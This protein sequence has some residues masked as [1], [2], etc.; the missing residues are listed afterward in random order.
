[1]VKDDF[2]SITPK[3]TTNL[4]GDNIEEKQIPSDIYINSPKLKIDKT[5]ESN[6]KGEEERLKYNIG[7]TNERENSI[8]KKVTLLEKTTNGRLDKDSI[9]VKDGNGIDIPKDNY[10]IV[11]ENGKITLKFKDDIYILGKNSNKNDILNKNNIPL[12]SN[13][14]YDKINIT[15]D[16]V[17]EKGKD[18]VSTSIVNSN[19]N[20][21]DE[22]GNDNSGIA[23]K[24]VTKV[25]SV[26]GRAVE[27]E[28]FKK[29]TKLD[30][31]KESLKQNVK[32]GDTNT[33]T[34]NILNV[35]DN[36]ARIV[37]VE[38][39][40]QGN[41]KIKKDS[42][43]I[44]NSKGEDITNNTNV[45]LK[46][47]ITDKKI[48]AIIDNIPKDEKYKIVYDVIYDESETENNV[49]TISKVRGLNTEE[50]QIEDTTNVN[51]TIKDTSLEI[52]K[53]SDKKEVKAGDINTYTVTVK[54]T[55]SYDSRDTV[56]EDVLY[57]DAKYIKDTIKVVDKDNNII[58]KSKYTIEWIDKK[59]EKDENRFKIK[60]PIIEKGK[61]IIVTY[62]VQYADLEET[63]E[64]KNI[65]RAKGTNTNLAEP[66]EKDGV[67]VISKGV[68]KET[69]VDITKK[70]EK[71]E[72]PAGKKN[73][74]TI[75]IRN[76]GDYSARNVH[77]E[78]I[79][80][81]NAK[82]LKDTISYDKNYNLKVEWDGKSPKV[83][84]PVLKSKEEYIL[85][86]YM[87]YID[88]EQDYDVTNTVKIKGDNIKEK[89]AKEKV[90]VK[91]VIKETTLDIIKEVE[92]KTVKDGD[93]NTYTTSIT[94]TGDYTARNVH[95]E[96]N[97]EGNANIIKTSVKVINS[98]GEDI[99]KTLKKEDLV[100]K[101][102]NIIVNIPNISSKEK[103]KIIYD[104][105]YDKSEKDNIVKNY[106]K[107]KRK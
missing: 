53:K 43:R 1:M 28:E 82:Y 92:K 11:E 31:S 15:Y 70:A 6:Y 17:K 2:E 9:K 84:I 91:G 8:A 44:L 52:S 51:G 77:I 57:G 81:G 55:G 14:I 87:E 49:K 21:I 89:E 95:I 25:L 12:N 61:D 16:V 106:Y 45:V 4:T 103:Y 75:T 66:K 46:K 98:K 59:T 101:D 60:F 50:K 35:G 7:I 34:L 97:I 27:E 99:T 78:D 32:D 58:D 20:T 83:I 56:V 79:V 47:D 67:K 42:V 5:F 86:Y 24:V 76:T 38:E 39:E 74:Y 85:T 72:M 88:S 90:L 18:T 48:T 71:Q 3:L 23:N 104:V 33:Y 65:I 100:V 19:D 13:K 102:N 36:P 37:K 94:N 80:S 96:E 41:A 62:N 69:N 40:L 64:I 26:E 105:K 107:S 63:Q 54:N 29:K 30:I 93:I 22:N 10:E 68:I 73:K